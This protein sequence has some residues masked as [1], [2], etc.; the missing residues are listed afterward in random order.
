MGKQQ[1]EKKI[2]LSKGSFKMLGKEYTPDSGVITLGA[3]V[4][5]SVLKS[6]DGSQLVDYQVFDGKEAPA[7]PGAIV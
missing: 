5:D 1:K 3:D 6:L 4:A 7:A 2:V